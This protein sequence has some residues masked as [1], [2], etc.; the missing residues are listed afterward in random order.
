[1]RFLFSI[2]GM[3]ALRSLRKAGVRLALL[4]NMTAKM[5][6]TEIRNSQLDGMLDHV[7]STD[8]VKAYKPDRRAYQMGIDALG[9]KRDEILCAAFAGWDAD[10]P[11]SFGYSEQ[12]A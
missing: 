4:S 3:A 7:L 8:R 10:G 12:P 5:L 6:Q 11:K 2:R 1:M 9:L